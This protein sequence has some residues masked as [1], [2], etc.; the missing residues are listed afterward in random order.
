MSYSGIIVYATCA[1]NRMLSKLHRELHIENVHKSLQPVMVMKS[2]LSSELVCGHSTK[3]PMLLGE[4]ISLN[5]L[6]SIKSVQRT[7]LRSIRGA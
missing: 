2:S 3:M 6:Q 7:L 5:L 1:K 4:S